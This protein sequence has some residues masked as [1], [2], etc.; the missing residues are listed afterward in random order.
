MINR[1]TKA[2][3]TK[4]KTIDGIEFSEKLLNKAKR[5]HKG[6]KCDWIAHKD[7]EEAFHALNPHVAHI[8]E[9]TGP[10]DEWNEAERFSDIEVSSFT[11]S[12]EDE[13]EGVTISAQRTLG[14]GLVMSL[15]TPFIRWDNDTYPFIS[16]L[17]QCVNALQ[18]EIHLYYDGKQAPKRQLEMF[19]G[20]DLSTEISTVSDD[21]EKPKPKRKQKVVKL[22]DTE[23]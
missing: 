23:Q 14:S 10:L 20:D 12:G 2:K 7:L 16:E 11:V 17:A 3:I 22:A 1:I 9:L 18:E 8:C 21:E 13:Y 5:D 15:N 19:A 4:E 6:V